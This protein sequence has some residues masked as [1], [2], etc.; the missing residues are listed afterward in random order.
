MLKRIIRSE[1]HFAAML[2]CEL[3]KPSVVGSRFL[4]LLDATQERPVGPIREVFVEPAPFRD[5]WKSLSD[6]ERWP[7]V[8]RLLHWVDP[9]VDT[10]QIASMFDEVRDLLRSP[11]SWSTDEMRAASPLVERLRF[12]FLARPDLLVIT[13]ECALWVELKVESSTPSRR[14]GY[15]QPE[16][17]RHIAE[18]ARL[19]VPELANLRPLNVMIQREPNTEHLHLT[20]QQI[21]G[22]EWDYDILK[23]RR[24]GR[25]GARRYRRQRDDGRPD[26]ACER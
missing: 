9:T 23:P 2:F 1:A 26:F 8:Q 15:W 5:V 3:R 18:A 20:W 24:R 4:A 25:P 13:T 11:A 21:V 14:Q 19:I 10:A 17:Q 22:D 12:M 6:A 7:L 16:T